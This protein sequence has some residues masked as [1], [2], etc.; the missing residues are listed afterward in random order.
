MAETELYKQVATAGILGVLLL[1]AILAIIRL[2][3][4]LVVEK[5]N[6]I[7]DA[8]KFN[9]LALQM[10]K[11]MILATQSLVKIADSFE[12]REDR[13]ERE[14][15]MRTRTTPVAPFTPRRGSRPDIVT[16]DDDG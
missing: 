2:Y 4:D 15:A 14:F 10:Q 1:M 5:N 9:T 12:K 13:L 7:E 6:R 8:T 3:R 11:E 16:E